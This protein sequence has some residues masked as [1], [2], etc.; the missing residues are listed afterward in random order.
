MR[1]NI[2]IDDATMARAMK[3]SGLRTKREVVQ[4]AMLELIENRSRKSLATLKGKIR[5]AAGYDYK[6][7]RAGKAR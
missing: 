6:A 4:Q 2:V 7:L 1:T 3:I 5:F